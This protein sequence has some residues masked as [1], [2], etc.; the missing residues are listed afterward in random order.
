[1][2]LSRH[3]FRVYETQS[4]DVS[5]NDELNAESDST[6]SYMGAFKRIS[7]VPKSI[8]CPFQILGCY[9]EFNITHE[10]EWVKHNLTH[11][12]KIGWVGAP[13]QV[14]PPKHWRCYCGAEVRAV[15]G[16]L[17][18]RER[19]RHVQHHHEDGYIRV[20]T[21]FALIEYLWANGLL[22]QKLYRDL[23]PVKFYTGG[24]NSSTIRRRNR[25]LLF[26]EETR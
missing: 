21:D 26:R 23:I 24:S 9:K 18:W 20:R 12:I 10:E 13:V 22:S 4:T 17:C 14:Q 1:M 11:F 19:M 3:S 25:Q 5:A 8:R 15:S 2:K 16:S 6:T 7:F